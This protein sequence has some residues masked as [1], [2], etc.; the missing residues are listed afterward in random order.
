MLFP[1]AIGLTVRFRAEAQARTLAHAKLKE[2]EQLARELHDSVAHH[3]TAITLQAQAARA[4]L[5]TRPE[6]ASK[7]LQAIEDEAKKTLSDLRGIVGALRDDASLLPQGRLEDIASFARDTGLAV[8][9]EFTGDLAGLPESVER[10]LYRLAQESITNAIKHARNAT[11]IEIRVAAE[12]DAI[13][14]SAQDDGDNAGARRNAG[15]GLVG[16]AE[17]VALLRGTFAAGPTALGW[18]V[19]A[20]LPRNGEAA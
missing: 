13:H 4:V 10:A 19:D 12:V 17:R 3:V 14:L 1:G 11:Q 5:A 16:M 20:S 18:R 9:V 15:F 6:A 7:A 2:R 8:V